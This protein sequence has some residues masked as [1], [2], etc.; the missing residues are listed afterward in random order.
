VMKVPVHIRWQKKNGEAVLPQTII[1]Q[2]NGP[3]PSILKAERL[4]LNIVQHLGGIATIT[5]QFVQALDNPDIKIVDTRKT[6]PLFRALAKKAVLAGGGINHRNGLSDMVLFKENH[7]SILKK[8]GRLSDLGTIIKR[9]KRQSSGIQVEVE[10]ETLAQLRTLDL[11]QA[12]II[13]L[14][15]FPLDQ[16]ES[17]IQCCGEKGYHAE[18]EVSGNVTLG[19]IHEYRSFPIHRIA[20]GCLTHSVKVL[21]LT[22]KLL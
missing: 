20:I 1:G 5:H 12:D 6:T 17:A 9:F 22:L 14:Y 3:E 4:F 11:E 10:I 15:N 13:M 2:L 8:Q 21:D 7:L 16:I 19:N 18:I